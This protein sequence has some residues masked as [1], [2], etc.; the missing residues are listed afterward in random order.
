MRYNDK[1]EIEPA[2]ATSWEVVSPSVWRF[3][4]REGVKFHDGAAD[5]TADDALASLTRVSDET[6]PLKGNL[7]TYKSA[8]KIDDHTVEI[9]LTGPYPLLLNDLTNI[10]IFDQGWPEAHDS[11]KPT[12]VSAKKEGYATFNTN[13]TGP[14]KL[15]SR[16]P[17]SKTVLVRNDGWWDRPV[18]KIDRI[19]FTPIASA[20]TRVAALLSG[21]IDFTEGA[22]VQDLGRLEAAPGIKVLERTDMRTVMIGFNRKP[23]LTDGRDN[24]FNDLKVRQAFELAID[25]D[26]I[27]KRVMRGKSRSAGVIVA[28]DI[29]GYTEALDQFPKADPEK[30]KALLA[31]SGHADLPFTFT[32]TT[33][34]YVNE[35]ELCNALVSMLTRAGF[36]PTLDIAPSGVQTPKRAGGQADVYIIGWAN[37]PMLDSYSILVQMIQTKSDTAGV[38][39]WGGWSYPAID[40]KIKHASTEMDRTKRLALQTEALKMAKDEIVMLPLHQQPVAWAITDKVQS[41]A[42]LADNK[43]RHWLTIMAPAK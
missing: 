32:C 27:Q 3:T 21:E 2:L 30:A 43:V 10:Q 38:F 26:L 34:S 4:L 28:P 17:D 20:A 14:F 1:L 42:Q 23:T 37:E 13:G 24:P 29:P 25:R 11:L 39:N 35:E 22:P 18:H 6:S 41:M 36:K 7:P 5:F 31:E 8:R 15:D 12:D 9:E 40:D 33:D 19:E 16:V